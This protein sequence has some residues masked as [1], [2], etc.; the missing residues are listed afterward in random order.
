MPHMQPNQWDRTPT[1]QHTISSSKIIP[2]QRDVPICRES[3]FTDT[4]VFLQLAGSRSK[5]VAEQYYRR[6]L[7]L[8]VS[9][10]CMSA[11]RLD[12]TVAR[13]DFIKFTLGLYLAVY[14]SAPTASDGTEASPISIPAHV[15][16]CA[17]SCWCVL[18]DALC[19]SACVLIENAWRSQCWRPKMSLLPTPMVRAAAC[20]LFSPMYRLY[21]EALRTYVSRF[22]RPVLLRHG[23]R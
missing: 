4:G 5:G 6:S 9:V 18:L 15:C 7:K 13:L 22:F 8:P 1:A 11:T 19:S 12:V 10:L 2:A 3:W 23:I 20:L 21:N 16:W 14:P 17:A